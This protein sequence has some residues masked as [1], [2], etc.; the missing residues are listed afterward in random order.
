M[1]FPMTV[2]QSARFA[3]S[4]YNRYSVVKLTQRPDW[5]V[6]PKHG[7]KLNSRKIGMLLLQLHKLANQ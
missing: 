1:S 5:L 6:C 3:K 2:G 4:I 7:N